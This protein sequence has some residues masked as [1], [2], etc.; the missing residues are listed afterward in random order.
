LLVPPADVL[1]RYQARV[2]DPSTAVRRYP[3]ETV[4]S[5]VYVGTRLLVRGLAPARRA[6]ACSAASTSRKTT[7]GRTSRSTSCRCRWATTHEQPDDAAFDPMLLRPLREFARAEPGRPHR[8]P[9]FGAHWQ[10]A[11][12]GGLGSLRTGRRRE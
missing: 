3:D 12:T 5:T 10:L 9:C 2:L 11:P 4:R 8:G 6:I 7:A 1:A